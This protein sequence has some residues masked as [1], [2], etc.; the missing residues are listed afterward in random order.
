MKN[1]YSTTSSGLHLDYHYSSE[2][3]CSNVFLADASFRA[4]DFA[5]GCVSV[6]KDRLAS[7]TFPKCW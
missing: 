4:R 6:I 2:P 3:Q 7:L 1:V 5:L